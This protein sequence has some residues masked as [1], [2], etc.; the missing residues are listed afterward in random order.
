MCPCNRLNDHRPQEPLLSRRSCDAE[1]GTV[2]I[3]SPPRNVPSTPN[4]LTSPQG[5]GDT[6]VNLEG[7]SEAQI[8]RAGR[9]DRCSKGRRGVST[10]A[11][12]SSVLGNTA[13]RS[14]EVSP[15]SPDR[16]Y[17]HNDKGAGSVKAV[18]HASDGHQSVDADAGMGM[19][20]RA[21]LVTEYE[22]GERC[23]SGI[24]MQSSDASKDSNISWWESSGG[25]SNYLF[26][27]AHDTSSESSGTRPCAAKWTSASVP[28]A[29][30]ADGTQ[31]GAHISGS[32]QGS[33][34]PTKS[35]AW[36]GHVPVW[37]N[38]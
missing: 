24:S 36:H 30:A 21:A 31:G 18:G 11:S 10:S 27:S 34:R 9:H 6:A 20:P 7:G 35:C 2:D 12:N 13:G 22:I 32:E 23:L 15:G 14:V 26:P 29:I 3:S 8:G 5:S 37:R 28:A 19:T 38:G 1:V 25:V 17:E 16:P 33:A 4:A